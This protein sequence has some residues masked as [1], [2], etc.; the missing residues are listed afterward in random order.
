MKLRNKFNIITKKSLFRKYI[1]VSVLIVFLSFLVLGLILTIAISNYW[2][3]EKYR[4]LDNRAQN[5]AE[6]I[7]EN[8]AVNEPISENAAPSARINNIKN[9]TNLLSFIANDAGVDILIESTEGRVPIV[10]KGTD[11]ATKEQ[12]EE[13]KNVYNN[14]ALTTE[15]PQAIAENGSYFSIGKLENHYTNDRYIAAR[16]ITYLSTAESHTPIIM[17]I[18]IV[19]APTEDISN[20]T[21]MVL[22]IFVLS[23][24]AA[25]SV[26]LLAIGLFSYNLVRPLKQMAQAAKQFGRGDF[27]VRVSET[28]NDEIGELAV[29]FNNMAE[30]L[31][32]SETTRKSFVANVSH[33]LKTPMTTIGGFIDGILDGTI[34]PEKHNYYLSIVSEEIKRLSRLVRSMLD[35]SRIDNGELKINYQKF[36]LY[37]MLITIVITF[38]QEIEK[39]NIEIR[40]LDRITPKTVY[41]DKD[42]IHQ[43]IYNLI[44][45]A[46]KFTNEGGYIA[47][48]ILEDADNVSFSITN[49][50][51]G[52]KKSEIPLVFE[53]FYK[54][55]KSRSKDKKGLGLGLYLVKSIIRLHG[56]DIEADSEY[57][58]YTIFR[59]YL[60]KKKD[61][62]KRLNSQH[63]LLEG[64][65]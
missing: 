33:E 44:E 34:P 41:G 9:I 35:L 60:P 64:G 46:V 21:D 14:M 58:Q 45:N 20:F 55:D 48:T 1:N 61:G 12:Q 13:N 25:L 57:G 30:S 11:K 32:S 37:S 47:F 29:A 28:S 49:S 10:V 63:N 27:S 2:A 52:I 38:E 23:A 15:I 5:Y 50:G 51:T 65:Q 43:V 17:G 22:K 3:N 40:G 8:A 53:R 24:V 36:D 31:S 42:L 4:Q 54:T 62:S 19:T 26:S 16:P 6:F 7:R 56:G 59:F 18:V 39:R